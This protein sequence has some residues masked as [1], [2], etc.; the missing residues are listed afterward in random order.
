MGPHTR[1]KNAHRRF[2]VRE[3]I[4]AIYPFLILGDIK[5]SSISIRIPHRKTRLLILTEDD[6]HDLTHVG[7]RAGVPNVASGH[8]IL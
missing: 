2:S 6:Q 3:A 4:I 1:T 5:I 7:S 8:R